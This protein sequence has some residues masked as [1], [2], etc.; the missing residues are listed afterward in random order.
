MPW[1]AGQWGDHYPLWP[2]AG[3][4]HVLRVFQHR[5]SPWKH[6][7]LQARGIV[8]ACSWTRLTKVASSSESGRSRIST[9]DSDLWA[10]SSMLSK[11]TDPANRRIEIQ[12]LALSLFQR[13]AQQEVHQS[14]KEIDVQLAAGNERSILLVADGRVMSFMP[15]RLSKEL[16]S[17]MDNPCFGSG[18][19]VGEDS[20]LFGVDS[21]SAHVI[22]AY[23]SQVTIRRLTFEVQSN[24]FPPL[25][26]GQLSESESA[27]M[28]EYMAIDLLKKTR[29]VRQLISRMAAKTGA[30]RDIK[31]TGQHAKHSKLMKQVSNRFGIPM[32]ERL[33]F[34]EAAKFR[35]ED[36]AMV[37]GRLSVFNNWVIFLAKRNVLRWNADVL[38]P[39]RNVSAA[40]AAGDQ[41]TI[42]LKDVF[43]GDAKHPSHSA[44]NGWLN[45]AGWILNSKIARR[46]LPR[47]LVMTMTGMD[48]SN[49]TDSFAKSLFGS[50]ES[51]QDTRFFL[52]SSQAASNLCSTVNGRLQEIA[53][54]SEV[55]RSNEMLF[56]YDR[57][58]FGYVLPGEGAVEEA[59]EFLQ[60]LFSVSEVKKFTKGEV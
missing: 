27:V 58:K 42:V 7:L 57:T 10:P 17:S 9:N 44:G 29:T 30:K 60:Q 28:Y 46:F 36:G 37:A 6:H 54:E 13:E 11:K 20:F 48:A 8:E 3:E 38:F 12:A 35:T 2:S 26:L 25:V 43:Q 32:T 34:S 18:S 5:L 1:H 40:H 15:N 19:L 22:K 41:L 33:L 50:A 56:S 24:G 31:M 16:D 51:R 21:S 47:K 39:M 49:L 53:G 52:P 55:A 14:G 59:K 4:A 23:S 45:S